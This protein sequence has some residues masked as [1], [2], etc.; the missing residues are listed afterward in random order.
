[1]QNVNW[2]ISMTVAHSGESARPEPRE[3]FAGLR[4]LSAAAFLAFTLSVAAQGQQT[5]WGSED[6]ARQGKTNS[7]KGS[8][9]LKDP[10][11]LAARDFMKQKNFGKAIEALELVIRFEPHSDP[12]VYIM[13]ATCQMNLEQKNQAVETCERGIEAF[14]GNI[15]LERF[16]IDL[17]RSTGS[18]QDMKAKLVARLKERPKSTNYMKNLGEILLEENPLDP[19]IE[20]LLKTAADASPCDPEAHYLYGQWACLND[21]SDLSIREL[22]KALTLTPDNNQ[23]RMQIY[24]YLGIAY[25]H[26]DRPNQADLA[27]R[28]A[29]GLNHKLASPNPG[30]SMQYADFL[31]KRSRE[32]EAEELIG[33]I[34]KWAPS[35]APAHMEQA[36]LLAKRKKLEE[37]ATEGELALTYSGT[38]L[39]QLRAAHAFLAKTYFALGRSQDAQLHQKW[40]ESHQ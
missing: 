7:S 29:L 5:I 37:A 26:L 16:Y 28:K 39:I 21:R 25:D 38:D 2:G 40:I 8:Q 27:F 24:V 15:R 22:T 9:A 23:A 20:P 6:A 30:T 32:G 1:M 33:Q 17:L 34:L 19:Q 13:L 14:P 12:E 18:K 31:L 4:L 36:K 10:N 35:F 11:V 3:F